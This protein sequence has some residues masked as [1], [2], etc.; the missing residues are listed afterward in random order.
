MLEYP[1]F[2]PDQVVP[3]DKFGD[4]RTQIEQVKFTLEAIKDSRPRGAMVCGERG[5]G[6]TSILDKTQ[7]MCLQQNILPLCIAL[8]E[9]RDIREFYNAIFEEIGSALKKIGLLQKLKAVYDEF[10]KEWAHIVRVKKKPKTLQGEVETRMTSL[11]DKMRKRGYK[12]LVFLLDES[13]GL[14]RHVVALQILRNVWM[15]LCKQGYDLGFFFACSENLVEDLG[16]YSPLKRH[17]IPIVLRRFTKEECFMV[18]D[19]LEENAKHKLDRNTKERIVNIS[20]GYPHYI[21]VLGN[22]VSTAL[23]AK[24]KDFWQ[25]AFKNYLLEINKYEET[26]ERAVKISNTQKKI[27]IAMDPFSP[28]TPQNIAKISGVT[29]A[30]IPMQLRRL[31]K[32][33]IVKK[34]GYSLYEIGNRNLVEYLKLTKKHN[35]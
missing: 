30:T 27:L 13:D 4:R 29:Q 17:C 34:S 26:I 16:K 22:Y 14:K 3:P 10:S 6:K 1:K 18:I 23:R 7:A 21:H 11:L 25:E 33:K 24:K 2:Y 9:F 31:I 28:I 5:I 20:G 12:S 8:H 32:Q 35:R 15:L 19:K